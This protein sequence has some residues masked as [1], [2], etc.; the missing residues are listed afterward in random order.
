MHCSMEAGRK[1][2]DW[3]NAAMAGLVTGGIMGLPVA[4]RAGEPKLALMAA[5]L[6][7][8]TTH[9]LLCAASKSVQMQRCG[10]FAWA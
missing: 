6:T 10:T 5:G 3:K 9:M 4:L 7:G 2:C 8:G 1:R